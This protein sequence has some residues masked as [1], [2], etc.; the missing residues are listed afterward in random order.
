MGGLEPFPSLLTPHRLAPGNRFPI[1][2]QISSTQQINHLISAD[3]TF[4]NDLTN[5][6]SRGIKLGFG[7]WLHF[8]HE[9]GILNAVKPQFF[10]LFPYAKR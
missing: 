4:E 7:G 3:Q 1:G 10:S 6:F 8:N 9:H 5:V 2:R